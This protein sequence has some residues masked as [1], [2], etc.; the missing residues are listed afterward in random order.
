[1]DTGNSLKIIVQACSTSFLQ[2]HP[3]Y[4]WLVPAQRAFLQHTDSCTEIR[5]GQ[6]RKGFTMCDTL[7][8]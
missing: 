2:E 4:V 8:M 5:E 6:Q 7:Q 3:Q 1:M